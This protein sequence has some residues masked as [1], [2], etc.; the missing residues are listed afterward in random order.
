VLGYLLAAVFLAWVFHGIQF[1]RLFENVSRITWSLVVLGLIFDTLA[2]TCAAVSWHFLL[3]TLGRVRFIRTAQ[4]VYAGLFL[5]E[6]LP[7]RVGEL[8]RAYLV[9]GWLNSDVLRVVP[10]MAL[11]R[12]FEGVWIAIGIG[13]T[14]IF[15]PLPKNLVRSADIFGLIVVAAAVVFVVYVVWRR[16]RPLPEPG[17]RA[18]P[19]GL[20]HRFLGTLRNLGRGFGDIGLTWK[21]GAAFG[22]TFFLFAFQAVCFWLLL[23]AYH[24]HLSFWAAAAVFLIIHFGT[25]LPNAPANI[26]AYQFFCVLGLRLFS[27]DKTLA[28]GFSF[29][30]FILLTLPLLGIG[31][32]AFG[33]SGLS[34]RSVRDRLRKVPAA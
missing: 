7:M 34:L 28:T 21:T 4:A 23:T 32:V 5:N 18:L 19:P 20:R 10:S 9:S 22:I 27:V 24:I 30:V 8:A 13:L 12:L 17:V 11:Q 2:Y 14:A 31:F 3:Q 16:R 33:Q 26:G 29:V 6:V 15:V 1:G 25:S